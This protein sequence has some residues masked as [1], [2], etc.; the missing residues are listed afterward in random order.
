MDEALHLIHNEI[1]SLVKD[2]PEANALFPPGWEPELDY[3]VNNAGK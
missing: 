3:L 2:L 1:C